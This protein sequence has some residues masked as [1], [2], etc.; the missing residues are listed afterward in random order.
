[1]F[2]SI[3]IQTAAMIGVILLAGSALAYVLG[4]LFRG[5]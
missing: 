5:N 2:W 4:K 1:M 3:F